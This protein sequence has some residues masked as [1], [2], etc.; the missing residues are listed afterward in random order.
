MVVIKTVFRAVQELGLLSSSPRGAVMQ[1]HQRTCGTTHTDQS[2]VSNCVALQEAYE[3]SGANKADSCD[4]HH[5]HAPNNTEHF[6]VLA[7]T[8]LADMMLTCCGLLPGRCYVA[9]LSILLK[10]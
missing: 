1:L 6:L 5:R 2:C 8:N 4:V 3:R 9:F 10:I 7:C